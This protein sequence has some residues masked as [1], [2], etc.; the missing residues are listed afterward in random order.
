MTV[1]NGSN[2]ECQ[3]IPLV[4]N[5]I[6]SCMSGRG[7]VNSAV[8]GIVRTTSKTLVP[9]KQKKL[10]SSIDTAMN[11][12]GLKIMVLLRLSPIIPFNLLNYLSGTTGISFRDY[13]LALFG[14]LPGT[15]LFVYIG[16][17]AKDVGSADGGLTKTI[18]LIVGAGF[19]FGAIV[20]ISYYAKAELKKIVEDDEEKIRAS[21]SS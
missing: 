14:I 9:V 1:S 13:T 18:F 6:E 10:W 12:H 2:V 19:G 21:T 8:A 11:T 4:E 7:S 15:C 16:A 3:A 20:M 5:D 17:T